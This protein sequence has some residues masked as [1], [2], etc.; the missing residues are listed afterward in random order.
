MG[1][2]LNFIDLFAGAGGLSEGFIQAG[3]KPI[4]HVEIEKSACNTL[5]TRAAYHFLKVNKE[6][7]TYTSYLKGEITREQLYK[8]IPNKILDSVINLPISDE[9]NEIIQDKIDKCLGKEEVDLIIGGP[10]CQ[11][12]SLVGRSRSKTKMEGDPR[13]Y[14]FVQYAKYLEKYNPRMFVFENV[15]GLKS[16]K[17]GHYLQEMEKLFKKKGYQIKLHTLEARNFGVLQNRK[18]IIILGWQEN[19]EIDL[20][21]LEGIKMKK[22]Y[23]V[24]S[25]L[26]DL[27][28]LKAGEGIDKF[29]KYKTQANDYLEAYALRNG[30][31]ILTQHVARPHRKQDREIYKIAVQK[32][33]DKKER[34][35]YNDLPERLKT[36]QNRTSF[37]D[38]FKVVAADLPYSQTVVAHIAK[39]GHYYI[40]PDIDQNRSLSA[41]EAA[42]LQSF[43]D[44]YYFEGEREGANRTAAFKQI[45]NAVPPLMAKEIANE[46]KRSL[47]GK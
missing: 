20:P 43:P 11:A 41:R 6:Y 10:P 29:Q 7:K 18:R 38:R 12:Y 39:D 4:A 17:G 24:E 36:H 9:N 27:P 13:N 42:R 22:E 25:V 26:Q 3:F 31:D 5:R 34:L 21:N 40:H 23:L 35:N 44:D 28:T 15:L 16:A 37:F 30:I 8:S 45:G 47:N 1:K 32:W 19:K 33:K 2:K 14:L 46:L